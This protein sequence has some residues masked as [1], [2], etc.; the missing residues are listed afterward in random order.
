MKNIAILILAVSI[1]ACTEKSQD[2]TH[3]TSKEKRQ[4]AAVD[5]TIEKNKSLDIS[6]NEIGFDL[7]YISKG[8][9]FLYN[10]NLRTQ[11]EFEESSDIFNCVFDQTSASLYYT[12]IDSNDSLSLKMA[13]INGTKITTSFI[14]DL[15]LH[16]SDC[17]TNTYGEKSK[18]KFN[19]DL[20]LLEH[21]FDWDRKWFTAL[22]SYDV[23]RKKLK[24][25]RVWE[26]NDEKRK[27]FPITKEEVDKK[28]ILVEL[29]YPP[30]KESNIYANLFTREVDGI[31][32]L[33]LAKQCDTIQL[34]QTSALYDDFVSEEIEFDNF[35]LSP[36]SSKLLFSILTEFGDLGHGPHFI[37][38]ING[39]AQK[40]METDIA[41]INWPIWWEKNKMVYLVTG[42]EATNTNDLNLI[43]GKQNLIHKISEDVDYYFVVK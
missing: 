16:R 40:R 32:E 5:S 28:R 22:V 26:P 17:E 21:N 7:G 38:N 31:L 6:N 23:K 10:S 13:T 9:L 41:K 15:H 35:L 11:R 3:N 37:V 36:D 30:K 24:N 29:M 42:H 43:Y 1:L 39:K 12:V 27:K 2:N 14:D 19:S 20:I 8:K 34:S 25:Y 33:F 4:N 18:L